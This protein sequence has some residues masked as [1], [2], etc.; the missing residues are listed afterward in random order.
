M[1]YVVNNSSSSF[2]SFFFFFFVKYS[3]EVSYNDDQCDWPRIKIYFF[4]NS[5]I[6]CGFQLDQLV[7]SLIVG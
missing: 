3:R 1:K 5:L 4:V 7:K 6:D 2:F